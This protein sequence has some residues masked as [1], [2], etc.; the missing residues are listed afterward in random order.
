MKYDN[1]DTLLKAMQATSVLDLA[2]HF[3]YKLR[4]G[5][6][7]SPFR[8]DKSA[9]FGVGK[10]GRSFRDYATGEGGGSW[11]FLELAL[12]HQGRTLDKG[13]RADWLIDFSGISRPDKKKLTKAEKQDWARQ[14]QINKFKELR[15]KH[16]PP[17]PAS[18]VDS[19][20]WS[21]TVASLFTDGTLYADQ[22][23][24]LVAKLAHG[25]GWPTTWAEQLI[26]IGVL[27]WPVQPWNMK[28]RQPAFLVAR[29][30]FSADKT[31]IDWHPV[32]FHQLHVNWKTEKKSYVY[33]PYI[34]AAE[35]A[36]NEVTTALRQ[37]GNQCAPYPFY[38]GNFDNPDLLVIC[39]GQWDALTWYGAAGFF[40]GPTF[41]ESVAVLG[42]RGAENTD[43]FLAKFAPWLKATKPAVW[44]FCD[45]DPAGHKW[46]ED[47][48]D[49]HGRQCLSFASQLRGLG[50][51]RVHASF[52]ESFNDFN[53]AYKAH[54]NDFGPDEI[55]EHL[56][57]L[58]LY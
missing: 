54:P 17:E 1:D 53:D 25:R 52:F 23:R 47:Y 24:A 41:S 18:M 11:K 34:P 16:A 15:K 14:K 46:R 55:Y 5:G 56:Q 19:A 43:K 22:D 31:A 8:K 35:K 42:I 32:G 39:E 30:E 9:S 29:P 57:N 6:N 44:L 27:A 36:K 21:P 7:K 40:D 4:I 3:G 49:Q 33:V 20:N 10:E 48:T 28:T 13:Q 26:E 2:E 51:E 38:I 50:L 12:Q 58:D 45:N 37:E